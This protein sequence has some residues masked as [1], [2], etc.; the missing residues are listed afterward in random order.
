MGVRN[1]E[2]NARSSR[3]DIEHNP[4]WGDRNGSG[5]FLLESGLNWKYGAISF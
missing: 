4:K 3:Q 2:S 1:D 5:Y